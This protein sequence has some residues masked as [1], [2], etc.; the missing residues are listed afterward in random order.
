MF[1]D[2]LQ[3][4]SDRRLVVMIRLEWSDLRYV[5]DIQ[6]ACIAIQT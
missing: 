5:F 2:A 6:E 4:Q 1:F 3:K